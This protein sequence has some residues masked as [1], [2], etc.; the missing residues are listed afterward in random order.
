MDSPFRPRGL[1]TL[2]GSLPLADHDEAC[3]LVLEYT[4]QIPLWIQLP[5]HKAEGMVAQFMPGLPGICST[6]DRVYI[7]TDQDDFEN[8]I[9]KFYEDYM[10]VAEG[11]AELSASRFVLN[12]DTARGFL[13]LLRISSAF[14][15]PRRRSR[16]R[17]PGRL[18]SVPEY[19]IKIKRP[20][21]MMSR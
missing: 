2:I 19:P 10:A 3:Q 5:V 17:L 12:E 13:F 15:P 18:L 21:S 20:L 1:P 6:A 14:P 16:A 7:D 9:L 8:D 4:P 11:D